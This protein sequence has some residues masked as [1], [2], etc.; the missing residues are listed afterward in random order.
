MKCLF[1]LSEVVVIAQGI[2]RKQKKKESN[3]L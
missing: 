1:I 3:F 2:F